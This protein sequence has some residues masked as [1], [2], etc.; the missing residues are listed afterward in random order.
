[1]IPP[2]SLMATRKA[3]SERLFESVVG[4]DTRRLY[5]LA[6]SILDDAGEAEDAVQETLLKAWR[7]W[8]SLSH[9]DR[10]SAWLDAG[11]RQPLHQSSATAA[12]AR[13]AAPGPGR[14]CLVVAWLG[15]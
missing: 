8:D 2:P 9:M 3:L 4:S 13:L 1:V 5:L 7:S 6:L 12:F 14:W 15:T 11:L 10:P